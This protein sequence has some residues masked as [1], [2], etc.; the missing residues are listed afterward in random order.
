MSGSFKRLQR[1]MQSEADGRRHPV[2]VDSGA[3]SR[4]DLVE[5]MLRDFCTN[6]YKNS[7]RGLTAAARQSC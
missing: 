1:K 7:S 6:F 4:L 3:I 5:Q 2:L